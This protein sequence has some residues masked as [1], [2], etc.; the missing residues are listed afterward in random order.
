MFSWKYIQVQS[1]GSSESYRR[2]DMTKTRAL[3][4]WKMNI[5]SQHYSTCVPEMCVSL[6]PCK[7]IRELIH[8]GRRCPVAEEV[9]VKHDLNS[10][11][12]GLSYTRSSA[13]LSV[14]PL[15][16][17]LT[18]DPSD[19]HSTLTAHPALMHDFTPGILK[20]MCASGIYNLSY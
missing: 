7:E 5:S 4:I 17:S 16:P 14:T 20:L 8:S 1:T 15:S 11:A 10:S 13:T 6:W 12:S 9:C 18:S 2:D 3:A 19:K